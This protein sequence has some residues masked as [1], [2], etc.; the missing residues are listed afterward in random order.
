MCD[1]L[2]LNVVVLGSVSSGKR[3]ALT[4][5]AS[6]VPRNLRDLDQPLW[7][8]VSVSVKSGHSRCCPC[9]R[10]KDLALRLCGKEHSLAV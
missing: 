9:P 4:I 6:S 10:F 2:K 1:E 5:G 3:A 8:P 7:A